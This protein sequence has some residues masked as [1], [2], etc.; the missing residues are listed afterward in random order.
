MQQFDYS[1]FIPNYVFGTCQVGDERKHC[2]GC[3]QSSQDSLVG[4]ALDWYHRGRGFKTLQ[5]R[6][7]FQSEFELQYICNWHNKV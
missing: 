1:F 5:G 3:Q 4:S 7:L 6:G 2:F